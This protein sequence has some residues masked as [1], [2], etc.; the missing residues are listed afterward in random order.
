MSGLVSHLLQMS[1]Q[2]ILLARRHL[3]RP[4]VNTSQLKSGRRVGALA[5]K[6]GMLAIFD[7]WGQRHAVTVLHLDA[8]EVL[9]KKTIE[10]DGYTALQLGV[11]EAKAKRV[12]AP[13]MGHFLKAGV[14]PKRKV[15]EFRVTPDALL[16]VGTRVNAVHFVPGQL[17]D[18][19][20]T[21]KGKGFQGVMKRWNFAG[22]SATHGN[23][24]SHRVPGSTGCRQ[25]PGRTFKNKKMPGRMGGERIT[26]QN[27]VLLKVDPLRD[28]LFVKGSVPGSAGTFIRVTDAVK[29]PMPPSPLPFPSA[30]LAM[31]NFE[32]GAQIHAPVSATDAGNF[33]EPV[34]PFNLE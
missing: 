15:A 28:L 23:S 27:L 13:A 11:G 32:A 16:P 31:M 33:K 22:G 14:K 34:D 24:V 10:T 18:V 6:V 8:C 20:G 3:Q 21:S 17:V 5:M 2:S 19:C 26:T 1:K 12:K 29:G 7:K 4:A 9:Q 25:D 30:T